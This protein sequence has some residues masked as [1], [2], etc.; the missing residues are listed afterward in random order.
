V[1]GLTRSATMPDFPTLAEAGLPGYEAA[2]WM[3]VVMPPATPPSIVARLNR[4]LIAILAT[5]EAKEALLAQGLDI[6][7][8]TPEA[9]RAR[10]S[11][12]REKWRAVIA[13]AGLHAE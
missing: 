9:L 8:S 12:D 7:A 13:K 4:E 5:V 1:T 2:L 3:A 6:E 10:I 11:A